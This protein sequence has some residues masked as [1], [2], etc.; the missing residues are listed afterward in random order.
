MFYNILL[1]IFFIYISFFPF[2]RSSPERPPIPS[3]LPLPLWGCSPVHPPSPVF[4]PWYSPKLGHQTHSGPSASPPTDVQQGHPLPHMGPEPWV[5]PH[6]L[7][8]WWSSPWELWEALT[9][10]H[11]CS[12]HGAANPLSS[13]SPF[14][15]SSIGDPTFSLMV[16]CEHLPLYLSGFAEL[17]RRHPYQAPVSKHFPASTTESRFGDGMWDAFAAGVVSV[18]PFL[19]SLLHTLVFL[20]GLHMVCELN[21]Q[22]SELLG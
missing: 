3:L 13:F 1:D 21:L 16:G 7:F 20:F 4:W 22:Y 2:F 5:P 18:W 10:W 11:C 12:L 8:G 17:L 6:V 19:Q 15:I 9:G 14:S